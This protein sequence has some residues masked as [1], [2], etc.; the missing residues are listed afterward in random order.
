MNEEPKVKSLYK[1]LMLLQY[2]NDEDVELG[3]TEIA[4][5]SGLLKSSVHNILQTFECCGY[6]NQ[7]YENNK[8][9]IGNA[10]VELFEKFQAAHKINYQVIQHLVELR[11]KCNSDVYLCMKRDNDIVFLCTEICSSTKR[12]SLNKIGMSLPLHCTAMGKILI[13]YQSA[14]FREDYYKN[15]DYA[16]FTPQ[17][18]CDSKQLSEQIQKA[19]YDGYTVSNEEY[20][21]NHYCVAVPIVIGWKPIQYS[22]GIGCENEISEYSLKQ[23]IPYIQ[24]MSKMIASHLL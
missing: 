3:V 4:G 20:S 16:R 7:N 2:F 9:R 6:V 5:K 14:E 8:Y 22:L 15:T 1:A 17:T 13:G 12:S 18:I 11:D 21:L 23:Y 24:E 19:I 10:A